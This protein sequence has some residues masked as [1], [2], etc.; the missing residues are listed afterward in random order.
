[1]EKPWKDWEGQ[2]VNGEYQLERFLG[3]SDRSGV[4]LTEH[5]PRKAA[6]KLMPVDLTGD[7]SATERELARLNA[8]AKLSHPHLLPILK[9]GRAKLEDL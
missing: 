3:G 4:F 8:A 7:A 1:M 5:G 2:V 6:I 9:T